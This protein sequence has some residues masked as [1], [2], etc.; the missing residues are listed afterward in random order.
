MTP[1]QSVFGLV[2]V[3]LVTICI[4]FLHEVQKSRERICREQG[5]QWKCESDLTQNYYCTRCGEVV[6]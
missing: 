5:H 1:E 6:R 3:A 2:F 4:A